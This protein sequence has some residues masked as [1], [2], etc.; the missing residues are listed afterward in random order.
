VFMVDMAG[1]S[2]EPGTEDYFTKP[3]PDQAAG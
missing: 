2:D 1:M 3:A